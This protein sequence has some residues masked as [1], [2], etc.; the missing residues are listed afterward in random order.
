MV[1]RW[2]PREYVQDQYVKLTRLNQDT[3][4]VDEYVKEFE[5][6][7]LLCDLDETEPLKMARFTRGLAKSI[8]N[9][10]DLLPYTTYDDVVKA[11]RKVEAQ[12][13]DNQVK[14]TSR[15][16][17]KSHNP[18]T[19]FDKGKNPMFPKRLENKVDER[20]ER[21][22]F[23]CGQKGHIATNCP[24]RN[25][26]TIQEG[27]YVENE[28]QEEDSACDE[29]EPEE[30]EN[31]F[32]GVVRRVLYTEPVQDLQQRENLFNTCCKV[33]DRICS[34]IIDSGSC[35]DV[36]ASELVNK[37]KLPTREH[38]KPYKLNWLDNDSG[39]RV[40]KQALVA[41]TVGNFCD[42][43]WCDVLPMTACQIFLGR[44][45][46]FDR[47]V[48]HNGV[49][50]VYTVKTSEGKQVRLL[51]LPPKV[52]KE[53]EEKP[54]FLISKSKF[55][56][57]HDQEGTVFILV[58]KP[59][60]EKLVEGDYPPII[61]PLLEEYHDV[62]PDE[63]PNELPP[64]RGIEHAIDLVPGAALPNKAAYRCNPEQ[65]KELQRQVEELMAKGFVR[66]SLSPC[67]VP[68]LLVPKKEGTWRMCIDSRAINNIIIKY[69]FPMP[70]LQDMLDELCGSKV[71][72][73][74]DLRSGYHQ[75]RIREGDE[76]KTAF[77][78][79]QGLY[80]WLVMPF[81]LCNA[82]S[83]FMR[84]MNEVLRPFLNKFIVVYLDDI[85]V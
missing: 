50:N 15:I 55:E 81:G 52:E 51:P 48:V 29:C 84:L 67:A 37:L 6:L 14:N 17:Y 61:R 45:W 5:R 43:R 19:R 20:G 54:N 25:T 18:A 27:G 73:K 80:E 33:K 62:F 36:V 56:E 69:R 2:I 24:K 59:I 30:G 22:C 26:L 66:E 79:K 7:S 4:I 46:Q 85:L 83:S 41:F 11:A 21:T 31:S 3:L 12:Q 1:Q 8:A 34:M 65:A 32:C 74:I 10:V 38:T 63:L 70:R 9:K 82:P 44:P 23:K 35:T 53:K 16:P 47:K 76:W 28:E 77:K 64:I 49:T 39:V 58:L 75:M 13:K 42:E 68:A 60:S 72:S 78:T 57:M 71:F 40:R